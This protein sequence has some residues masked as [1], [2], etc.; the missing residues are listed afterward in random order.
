MKTSQYLTLVVSSLTVGGAILFSYP[1]T[2]AVIKFEFAN[3]L[4]NPL[5]GIRSVL[6]GLAGRSLNIISF[7]SPEFP[8][9][10]I[11]N[12]NTPQVDASLVGG[13]LTPGNISS[14]ELNI[15]DYPDGTGGL[16]IIESAMV[17]DTPIGIQEISLP[18]D[19]V[20]GSTSA[21]ANTQFSAFKVEATSLINGT[22]VTRTLIYQFPGDQITFSELS[23]SSL[24]LKI[25]SQPIAGYV[26][27]DQLN[28][29]GP[30]VQFTFLPGSSITVPV[31]LGQSVPEPSLIGALSAISSGAFLKRKLSKKSEV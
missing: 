17:V 27:F 14:L 28:N 16:R 5:V 31:T 26:P 19:T 8:I 7:T 23:D 4:T 15:E 21:A 11:A 25:S 29:F 3:P 10:Q 30:S 9:P 22:T 1:A 18:T 20:T 6:G 12:N 13:A 24:T 2:S